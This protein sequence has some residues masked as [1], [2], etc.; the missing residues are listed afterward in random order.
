VQNQVFSDGTTTIADTLALSNR[1]WQGSAVAP[2]DLTAKG[3]IKHMAKSTT[4]LE[5][6]AM[7]AVCDIQGHHGLSPRQECHHFE[8]TQHPGRAPPSTSSAR[9]TSTLFSTLRHSRFQQ[10]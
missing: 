1:A 2:T 3:Y 8:E 9:R 5:Q 10:R 6:V 7:Q 4:F